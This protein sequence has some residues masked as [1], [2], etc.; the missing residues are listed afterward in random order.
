ML[1]FASTSFVSC[2]VHNDR[3]VEPDSIIV[4]PAYQLAIYRSEFAYLFYE[5]AEHIGFQIADGI[6][7]YN[8]KEDRMEA[9]FA[10][11]EGSFELDY[12]IVIL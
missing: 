5:T 12:A 6:F 8:Y 3:E 1:V 7:L 11:S 10:L 2:T 9:V 4:Q